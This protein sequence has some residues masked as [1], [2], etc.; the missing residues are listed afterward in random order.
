MLYFWY[1]FPEKNI[2][3]KYLG[4]QLYIEED[5]KDPSYSQSHVSISEPQNVFKN[6]I[7][8]DQFQGEIYESKCRTTKNKTI[9]KHF[10]ISVTK[11]IKRFTKYQGKSL[12][13]R[14]L[15]QKAFCQVNI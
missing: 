7:I 3:D 5:G 10:R 12:T 2:V 1:K 6:G 13:M 14:K 11:Q 15:L 9:K 4:F 8:S